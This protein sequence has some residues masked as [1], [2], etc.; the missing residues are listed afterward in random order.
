LN[1][2]LR[3]LNL[4]RMSCVACLA[5]VL[6]VGGCAP[7]AAT[8][9]LIAVARA[10]LADAKASQQ[11]SH[12]ARMLQFAQQQAALDAAFDTDV[13][14]AEAGELRDAQGNPVAMDGRWVIGARK[15]YVAARDAV[16]QQARSAQA[17][18]ATRQDNLAAADEALQMARTL[19][20]EQQGMSIR[21]RQYLNNQ[22]QV[23]SDK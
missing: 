23:T 9:E 17:V 16:A 18:H 14:L 11:Q 22:R 2:V 5:A 19:I 4:S 3:I 12:D 6:A 8:L 1:F 15:G 10:G 20:I 21:M 7:P 13:R